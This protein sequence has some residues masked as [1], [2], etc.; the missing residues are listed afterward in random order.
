MAEALLVIQVLQAAVT[1]GMNIAPLLG[2]VSTLIQ[3]R[4]SE[5]RTVTV[6]DLT[7]LFS[8]GDAIEAAAR[9]QFADTL[10]DPNTPRL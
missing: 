8:E 1:A 7:A 5:G 4:H 2:K 10:A 9:K 3:S 6:E